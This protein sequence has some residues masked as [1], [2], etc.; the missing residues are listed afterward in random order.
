MFVKGSSMDTSRGFV[1]GRPSDATNAVDHVTMDAIDRTMKYYTDNLLQVLECV[2]GRLS[3]LETTVQGLELTVAGLKVAEGAK[4]DQ[5]S[6]RLMKLELLVEEV[7]RGVQLLYEKQRMDEARSH[8]SKLHVD[9]P[10][11]AVGGVPQ[12]PSEGWQLKTAK[13]EF[14]HPAFS[15]SPQRPPQ[16]PQPHYGHT[17]P[18]PQVQAFATSQ[19]MLPL[20]SSMNGPPANQQPYPPAVQHLP[21]QQLSTQQ[22]SQPPPQS[23][24]QNLAFHS[25]PPLPPSPSSSYSLPIETTAYNH[26][27]SPHHL[28]PPPSSNSSYMPEPSQYAGGMHGGPRQPPLPQEVLHSS[29]H[30]NPV[31]TQP[32]Y[33]GRMGPIGSSSQSY[34]QPP[35]PKPGPPAPSIYETGSGGGYGAQ[36][37]RSGQPIPSAPSGGGGGYPRLPTAQPIQ[38][39]VPAASPVPSGASTRSPVDDVIDKVVSMGFR[40]EQVRGVVQH[41]TES[42]NSVELNVVLDKLMNGGDSSHPNRGWFNR[43]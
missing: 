21:P 23:V 33:D 43:G 14:P 36:P 19:N 13:E 10:K 28:P 6:G 30:Q 7:N 27:H 42:G 18:P 11:L 1:Y 20:P 26:K 24:L 16:Y 38:Y 35:L 12:S 9:E 34:A 29:Q 15:E 32:T 2:S 4:Q 31:G 39:G 37:Y 17:P 41:L 25:Q 22:A 5:S 3:Q 40:R 8:F